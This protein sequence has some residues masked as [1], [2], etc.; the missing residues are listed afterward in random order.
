MKA[1]NSAIMQRATNDMQT[2]NQTAGVL[3]TIAPSR[4]CDTTT[5]TAWSEKMS[6]DDC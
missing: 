2:T 6:A 1:H 3:F 5:E 4:S